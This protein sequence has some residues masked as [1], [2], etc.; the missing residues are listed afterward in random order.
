[1]LSVANSLLDSWNRP[2]SPVNST[3]DIFAWIRELNNNTHVKIEEIPF[4]KNDFWFYDKNRGE[5]LNKKKKFFFI[6]GLSCRIDD[7]IVAEQ[8]III[9]D[10]I[11]FLG[12]IAKEIKGILHFLMQAK[13]E[14]GNVNGVQVSPTIQAT[15]SNFTC[16]HGGQMPLYFDWFKEAQKYGV[17][18][19]DQIQSE[20]GSRFAGKRNRN[21]ILLTSQ[22]VPVFPN[23]KWMT[24][25]QIKQQMK[26]D[27][28]GQYGYAHGLVRAADGFKRS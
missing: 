20:Q 14:P 5:I 11:G 4:S 3:G 13:I 25:G 17:V 16:V 19:Y 26:I 23:Y 28:F 2:D 21:I 6:K 10:E 15:R 7:E 27:N 1:M 24:L 12:I 9:Q 22:D 18:L 8:P